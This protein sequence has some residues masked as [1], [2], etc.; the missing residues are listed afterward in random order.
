MTNGRNRLVVPGNG[1]DFMY[2]CAK[3]HLQCTAISSP[4]SRGPRRAR[5]VC[6]AGDGELDLTLNSVH[7]YSALLSR[8]GT[9][10]FSLLT[11][12][13]GEMSTSSTAR[14]SAM[15]KSGDGGPDGCAPARA[16]EDQHEIQAI[17]DYLATCKSRLLKEHRN[18][19]VVS[20]PTHNPS[21]RRPNEATCACQRCPM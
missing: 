7:P 9:E 10:N 11:A 21:I 13:S 6:A 19:Q 15:H 17:S 12:S 1:C 4:S 20:I 3:G 5:R 16:G 18:R 2:A 14:P 8:M